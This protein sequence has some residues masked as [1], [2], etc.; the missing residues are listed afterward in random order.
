LVYQQTMGNS[1]PSD[2]GY[3]GHP[4][5][6]APP[7]INTTAVRHFEGDVVFTDYDSN[8][9]GLYNSIRKKL[10]QSRGYNVVLKSCTQQNDAANT[11]I[12]PQLCNLNLIYADQMFLHTADAKLYGYEILPNNMLEMK[13]ILPTEQVLSFEGKDCQR[14]ILTGKL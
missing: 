1:A 2:G 13:Q 6:I 9:N 4:T 12:Q 8:L 10:T 11:V 7:S 3:Y 14:L 5:T